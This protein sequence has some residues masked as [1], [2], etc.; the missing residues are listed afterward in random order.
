MGQAPDAPEFTEWGAGSE[1]PEVAEPPGVPPPPGAD[2]TPSVPD[3]GREAW[4]VVFGSTIV[5]VHTWGLIN[6]FGVFQTYYETEL[7][8]SRSSSDISW[9]GSLQGALLMMGGIVSGPLYDAGYFRHLLITGNFFVV[10][11]MFMTSL[12]TE[13]YQVLLAQGICVGLGC[14]IMFLP[15]AALISQWFSHRRAIALGVQSVGS[16]I[17][18]IVLPIIFGRLQPKIGFAWTTRVISFILLGL[19]LIPMIFMK[20][21]LP[22]VSH[23]RSFIDKTVFKDVPFLLFVFASFFAFLG[24]YVAFFYVQLYSITFNVASPEFSPYFVTILNA[25]SVIGRLGP[26]Y[27]AD[28]FDSYN[29]LLATTFSAAVLAIAW[30]GIRSFAGLVVFSILY[31]AFSG[32]VVSVTPSAIV[33]YCPDMSRLGTRMGMCFSL[34][35]ISVLVGTPIGGAILADGSEEAWKGIILYSGATLLIAS[36]LLLASIMLHRKRLAKAAKA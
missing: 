11:G 14:A 7:L 16:P 22:P 5:L 13:Y 28:F 20:T 24:L 15:C 19:S 10:F 26:N 1:D 25:G 29:V 8:S 2:Q 3:G 17:A 9:I 6:S 34:A 32:G 23:K 30:V 33:P 35:G 12:C 31:G 18:G 4:L 36:I 21:R 27:A